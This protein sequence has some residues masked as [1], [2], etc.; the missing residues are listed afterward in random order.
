METLTIFDERG[1]PTGS[2]TFNP[3]D[4]GLIFRS[5][6]FQ[7]RIEE[8]A[9]H[10]DRQ[11]IK[12]DGTGKNKHSAAVLELAERQLYEALDAYLQSEGSCAE[13]FK[14]RRPFASTRGRFFCTRVIDEIVAYVLRRIEEELSRFCAEYPELQNEGQPLTSDHTEKWGSTNEE[15]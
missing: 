13:L 10:L 1:K 6:D 14:K 4:T 3:F 8:I 12:A 11:A 15:D 2:I 5:V 7:K 9:E